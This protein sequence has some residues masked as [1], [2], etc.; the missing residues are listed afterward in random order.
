MSK[1]VIN[2]KTTSDGDIDIDMKAECK[3]NELEVATGYLMGALATNSTTGMDVLEAL[4]EDIKNGQRA[5]VS[6][7]D[8]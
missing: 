2:L 1:I 6:D 3:L 7:E 4:L 8:N 5:T